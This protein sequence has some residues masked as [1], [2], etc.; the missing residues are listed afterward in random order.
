MVFGP[1]VDG[2]LLAEKVADRG[3]IV[4]G[5]KA[6]GSLPTVALDGDRVVG[7][8]DG[9]GWDRSSSEPE[10]DLDL[11]EFVP[12][13]LR[14]FLGAA[15]GDGEHR[16]AAIGFIQVPVETSSAEA[17]PFEAF[18]RFTNVLLEQAQRH[19]VNVL[20][21]DC[22]VGGIGFMLSAGA[23]ATSTQEED[24]LLR[25][26]RRV[27]EAMPEMPCR[28]GVTRG[29][30]FA[31][32]FGASFRAYYT[33][34]GDSVNLAAR[35]MGHAQPG[36]I[37][38]LDGV[39]ERSPTRFG[40]EPL[41]AITL[42]GKSMPVIPIS[43]GP[44][45]GV[46][47]VDWA[48]F[49]PLHGRDRELRLLLFALAELREERG[50]VFEI[51]GESGIGKTRLL[52][53][54]KDRATFVDTFEL[55]CEQYEESTPYHVAGGLLRGVMG[56]EPGA[57]DADVRRRLEELL[58]DVPALTPWLPLL[59][60][61]LGLDIDDSTETASLSPEF[62]VS[63]LHEVVEAFVAFLRPGPTL[64]AVEDD[65][66]IDAASASLLDHLES[67]VT[68]HPWLFVSTRRP[69]RSERVHAGAVRIELGPLSPAD[70]NDLLHAAAREVPVSDQRLAEIIERSGGH[71]FFALELLRSADADTLPESVEIVIAERIDRLAPD[72]RR[73]LR[74]MSVLGTS[75]QGDLL[76]ETLPEMHAMVDDPAVWDRLGEFVERSWFGLVNFRQD[77]IRHVAYEALTI[78]RRR[79]I[80]AV[81]ADA[82][83]RFDPT[84]QQAPLLAQHHHRAGQWDRAWRFS[85][86]AAKQA[87][88]DYAVVDAVRLFEQALDSI[89]HLDAPEESEALAAR[90]SLADA[91]VL[92]GMLDKADTALRGA[93]ASI[94]PGGIDEAR[95][96][97]KRA[98]LAREQ[99]ELEAA[100]KWIERGLRVTET[101][102]DAA[103]HT[104][105]VE[106]LVVQ[107]GL[108]H[109]T[110]DFAESSSVAGLAMEEAEEI[111]APRAFANAALIMITNNV[112]L[113]VDDDREYGAEAE[114]VFEELGDPHGLAKT[115]NNQGYALFFKGDWTGA[116]DLWRRARTQ[117]RAAGDA[118]G[119]AT[120]ENNLGEILA[121]QGLLD[122]AEHLFEEALRAWR[123][124]SFALGVA[125]A[126]QNLGRV[127]SRR[128]DIA[129]ASARL[130]DALGRFRELESNAYV[131]D[132]LL[133]MAELH[134]YGSDAESLEQ[135]LLAL[136]D[137]ADHPAMAPSRFRLEALL[138]LARGD[139]EGARP[140]IERSIKE[141]RS[142]NVPYQEAM[143][144]RLLGEV[145][146]ERSA[147]AGAAQIFDRMGASGAVPL[148]VPRP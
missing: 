87:L 60:I 55:H 112:S 29:V 11:A 48:R 45:M 50:G 62:R 16:H 95:L 124:A 10:H 92:A 27:A 15:S 56:L 126:T 12:D 119:A 129:S 41:E 9:P 38:T 23:P 89:E 78:R 90:E 115:L 17:F 8:P 1:A 71:P 120:A 51:V 36:T 125:L 85:N 132:T 137:D 72:D 67:S 97:R 82:I 65:H 44:I 141:A 49:L 66:W 57:D 46:E 83:E 47:R 91:A 80:H 103:G 59:G 73:L 31:G 135:A 58:V 79:Q 64:F 136:P 145:F 114:R 26:M 28:M 104:E 30:V 127:A 69:D 110:G 4:V 98:I 2:A 24:R 102:T 107:T 75:F 37:L 130:D 70:A 118:I 32:D 122:E 7:A 93:L 5:P 77:V 19:E 116:A 101:L 20:A 84:G 53:E 61:P 123:A 40:L 105:R 134:S 108:L 147:V 142:S 99:G 25:T 74:E 63:R 13:G 128:G 33:L 94:E 18:D 14:P 138:C 109:R 54:I 111:G 139:D 22:H 68:Q 3:Q 148:T 117:Y 76:I 133:R 113:G 21:S 81:V 96:C 106:Q 121:D 39:L 140:M 88:D 43:V 143:S 42:K 144:L 146:D 6:R 35:L 131:A 100:K 86:A 52:D 34:L